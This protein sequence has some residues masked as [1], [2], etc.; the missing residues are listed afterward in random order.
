M[1]FPPLLPILTCLGLLAWPS[2]A[3]AVLGLFEDD[4]PTEAPSETELAQQ[5]EA[6]QSMLAQGKKYLADGKNGKAKD[7]FEKV[8]EKY[9]L[10]SAASSCQFE[11]ARLL[12][13]DNDY[14]KSFEAYQKFIEQHKQSEL[15]GEAVQRQFEI[16]TNSMTGKTGSFLGMKAKVQPSRII[17]LYEQIAVNAP[18]S[19]FA[20]LSLY[21]IGLLER[22]AGHD[23]ESIVA[24]QRVSDKYPDSPLAVEARKRVFEI[25]KSNPTRDDDRFLTMQ[26]ELEDIIRLHP[27]DPEVDN[28]KE[29]I[30]KMD[31]REA[32]KKF[33][34]GRYYE[35]KGN[36][37]AAAIYYQDVRAG[38]ARYEDAQARLNEL[39][40]LDPN[41]VLPPRAP[42]QKVAA[43]SNVIA[44]D[45]YNGPP[46]PA[47]EEPAKP[48]MRVSEE[49]VLP[50]PTE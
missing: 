13:E 33:N 11:L 43:T 45:D 49:E 1:K 41:L 26:E 7:V 32:E 14:L 44:R 5:E 12:E 16:A 30:G 34:I 42:K 18:Y 37:R 2:S 24:F 17:E 46:A 9:P 3:S 23:E 35:K 50:L 40:E 19:R 6:A 39:A 21:N 48:Q 27:E 8:S 28:F 4:K 29:E 38:T 25:R 47:L 36:P 15:Y 31:E 20:P 22:D 10:T